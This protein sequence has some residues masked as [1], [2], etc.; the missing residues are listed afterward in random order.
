MSGETV[1]VAYTAI[2]N[3][4]DKPRDDIL[5]LSGYDKF[6]SP[7]LNA[8]IYKVLPHKF[9]DCEVSFWM[10]GNIYPLR[11][12]PG[13]VREWLGDKDIALFRHYKRKGLDWEVRMIRTVHLTTKRTQVAQDAEIQLQHYQDTGQM[14]EWDEVC[15]GGVII[16]RHTPMVAKFNEAWWA[17]ICR[18]SQRDQL[19][20]PVVLKRFPELRI[21]RID[22]NIKDHPWIRYEDH[23]HYLT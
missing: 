20:L 22:G 19:S 4:K 5:C 1:I 3:G 10:D 2:T 17:E 23:E 12:I 9:L 21:N 7:V 8:K 18:W 14:P 6:Q 11:S 15:M 13:L 16:R